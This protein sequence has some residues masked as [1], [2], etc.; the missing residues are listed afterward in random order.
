MG[1][2]SKILDSA[3]GRRGAKAVHRGAQ[4][5]PG[6]GY[7]RV[8]EVLELLASEGAG[9]TG[10]EMSRRLGLPKSTAFLLLQHLVDRGIVSLDPL[11]RRYRTGPAL[12]QLAFQITAGI[13]LVRTARPHLDRLS[14]ETT[15]DVYLGIR[16]GTRFIYVDK[17]EGTQSVRLNMRLGQPRYLH[18]TA[19]GKLLL[20]FGPPELLER[21]VA[22][23]G[24]PKMTPA[25]IVDIERLRGELQRI[26]DRG[27]SISEAENVEGVYGFAAPVRDYGGEVVAA[28]HISTLE[29]RALTHRDF[30][31]ERMCARAHELS[32]D[33]GGC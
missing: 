11:T 25:T 13:D 3:R 7:G 6:R 22:E 16:Q 12:V 27:Y 18:S 32:R 31:I 1:T 33:L 30:L 17:L 24:L 2:T 23:H 9:L 26:R 15:D 20:A 10:S 5:P 19:V 28:V 4:T 29:A 14:Q 8:I 21:V